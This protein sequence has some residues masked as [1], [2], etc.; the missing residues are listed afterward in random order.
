M[1]FPNIL[2]LPVSIGSRFAVLRFVAPVDLFHPKVPPRSAELSAGP[3]SLM[4]DFE[5]SR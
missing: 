2:F 1:R 5:P 4:L 3:G